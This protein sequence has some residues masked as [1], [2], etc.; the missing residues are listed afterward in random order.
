MPLL[1]GSILQTCAHLKEHC[2][3]RLVL[4]LEV[5][6]KNKEA[7]FKIH[8]IVITINIQQNLLH[9][10]TTTVSLLD[11]VPRTQ[12]THTLEDSTHKIEG[13]TPKTRGQLVCLL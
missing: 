1:C 13:Q 7:L 6:T 4:A 10:R 8:N 12:M 5:R 11:H 9:N 3:N 2:N